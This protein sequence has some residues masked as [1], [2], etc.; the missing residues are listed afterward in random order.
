MECMRNV[1]IRKFLKGQELR[2]NREFVIFP[3][4]D[5]HSFYSWSVDYSPNGA[6]WDS[7]G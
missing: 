7:P 3:E 1:E 4:E 6:E 2:E 5:V